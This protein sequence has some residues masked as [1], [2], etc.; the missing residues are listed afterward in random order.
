MRRFVAGT[1]AAGLA[2][3]VI[4]WTTRSERNIPILLVGLDGADWDVIR[5][6]IRAGRLPNLHN[7]SEEGA[8]G[9]LLSEPP[10]LSPILWTTIA[11]GKPPTQHG[12]TSFVVDRK[13]TEGGALPVQSTERKCRALWNI[14]SER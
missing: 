2:T 9:D 14:S 4:V 5:P 8:S 6:M 11:T 10:L 3:A 12:I 1:L 13:G 7:L